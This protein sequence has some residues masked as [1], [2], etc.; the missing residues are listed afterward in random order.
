MRAD[1]SR[2]FLYPHHVRHFRSL[3]CEVVEAG[4]DARELGMHGVNDRPERMCCRY[5]ALRSQLDQFQWKFSR[6]GDEQPTG[7]HG[8]RA[9]RNPREVFRA[10]RFFPQH[11]AQQA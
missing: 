4:Q 3:F 8:G 7:V 11:P 5:K 9:G 1:N 2:L 10:L 6:S